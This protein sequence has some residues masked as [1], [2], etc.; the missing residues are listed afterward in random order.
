MLFCSVQYAI[1]NVSVSFNDAQHIKSFSSR[2]K[3]TYTNWNVFKSLHVRQEKPGF[4]FRSIFIKNF[5]LFKRIYEELRGNLFI[6]K[7]LDINI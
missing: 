6:S 5:K 3:L 7:Y 1:W 2:A 4:H